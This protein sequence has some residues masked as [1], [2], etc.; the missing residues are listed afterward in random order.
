MRK[1]LQ[2]RLFVNDFSVT[3]DSEH[4][5]HS[6]KIYTPSLCYNVKAKNGFLT[7]GDGFAHLSFPMLRDNITPFIRSSTGDKCVIRT[8]RYKYYSTVNA[9]YEYM[10]LCYADDHKLYFNNMCFPDATYHPVS[11]HVFNSTP[12]AITFKAEGSDVIAFS[13]PQDDMLVWY[14]DTTPYV[15]ENSFKFQSICYHNNRLF[16]IDATDN[17]VVKYSA[18]SN[19]LDW[20]SSSG[21]YSPGE[22][23]MNDYKDDL[24]R[25]MS[26]DNYVYVFRE[27]GIS[28]IT[29]YAQ[30][31]VYSSSNIYTTVSKIYAD[32]AT[33]CGSNIYFLQEDGLYYFD[34][35]YVKKVDL[36]FESLLSTSK[37]DYANACFYNG[38]YYLACK[39]AFDDMTTSESNMKNNVLVAFDVASGKSSITRGVD[40]TDM[41]A[42]KDELIDRMVTC[43]RNSDYVWHLTHDGKYDG[44]ALPK[45]WK[46]GRINLGNYDKDKILKKIYISCQ[47]SCTF[48]VTTDKMSRSV[49]LTNKT[50]F[51][52]LVLNVVGREFVFEIESSDNDLSVGDIELYFAVES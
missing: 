3:P 37:Q 28:R 48:R 51:Q 26:L 10:L 31:T 33:I 14:T 39:I 42:V 15:V 6:V 18:L 1:Y 40:V 20:T 4:N 24:K 16:A 19:P 11:S 49:S 29:P 17:S 36:P 38:V 12:F 47:S 27:H 21:T 5:V 22:I 34:G 45:Y 25:L 52:R 13:S 9:R 2:K 50:G 8:W 44:S 46:S 32:T 7:T 23:P 35:F 43:I 30:D 41:T